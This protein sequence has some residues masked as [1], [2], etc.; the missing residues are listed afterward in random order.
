MSLQ[1]LYTKR[2]EKDVDLAKRRG[3]NINKLKEIIVK[4]L[5][6]QPL[7]LHYYDHYLAGNYKDRRE[8]HIESDWLLIYKPEENSI[9]F[10][11]TGTHSDLFR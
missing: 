10:E 9:I 7:E 3:K 6:Q 11:R 5:N 8:C 4:L 1:P 2:F